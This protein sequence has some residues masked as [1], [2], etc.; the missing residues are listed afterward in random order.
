MI[1]ADLERE[2]WTKDIE[3]E[4]FDYIIFADVLE[5]LRDPSSAVLSALLYLKSTGEVLISVPN[6]TY[7]GVIA[8]MLEGRFDYRRDGLLDETHT[9]F[10]T[11]RSLVQLLGKVGLVSVEWDRTVL[12]PEFSEFRLQTN[13]LGAATRG[14]LAGVPDGDTYQFLVRCAQTGVAALAAPSQKQ[15]TG[16]AGLSAQVYFDTGGGFSEE[17]SQVLALKNGLSK[18]EIHFE[19]PPGIQVIRFDPVDATVPLVIHAVSICTAGQELLHWTAEKGPLGRV[20]GLVNVV[21]L[22]ARGSSVLIP[23][24]NDPAITFVTH[25]SEPVQVSVALSFTSL[26]TLTSLVGLIEPLTQEL[27]LVKEHSRALEHHAKGIESVNETLQSTVTSQALRLREFQCSL[28][29]L[30]SEKLQL[31]QSLNALVR[32]RS[33]LMTRPFRIGMRAARIALRLSKRTLK[34]C[35]KN[36]IL[37]SPLVCRSR[38]AAKV[39]RYLALG[40]EYELRLAQVEPRKKELNV[41]RAKAETLCEPTFSILMPTF[42]TNPGWLVQAIES[43]KRQVYPHWELCIVDDASEDPGV[44]S[45]L[46]TY[47]AHDARIKVQMLSEN[48]HISRASNAALA[49]ATG[50]YI[51]L[52]DHDDVLAPHALFRLAEVIHRERDVDVIYSDEDKISGD[53]QR[54]EPTCK[55]EWSPDYFLSF[56]YTGH[57][58]CFRTGIVRELEGFRPGFEGSQDYDLMLRITERTDR[59]V[60]IPEVLYH[61]RAHGESVAGN[62][63]CKPYAFASAK[64]AISQALERRGFSAACVADSRVRGLYSVDRR[65]KSVLHMT[66]SVLSGRGHI[67]SDSDSLR[68]Y[69][70][71]EAPKLIQDL[72]TQHQGKDGCI[73]ICFMTSVYPGV[74]D[75]LL[76]HC[77]DDLIGVAAP[78]VVNERRDVV[79]AGMS[80][81]GKEV[82]LNFKGI[83]STEIGYRGRLVVPFNVSLVHPACVVFKRT[84][85]QDLP[86]GLTSIAEFVG[87]LCL[88]AGKRGLRCVVDPSQ[89]V[90]VEDEGISALA[91]EELSALM[92]HFGY[93]P[94]DDPFL[95]AG[96]RVYVGCREMPAQ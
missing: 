79:A 52:L 2:D 60:H 93:K 56:M 67:Q 31:E 46:S 62:L 96:L 29:G 95:P 70:Q 89:S 47:A 82:V 41:M 76:D 59:I 81:V 1:V 53:G 16:F 35:F 90:T 71:D 9:H 4:K 64:K 18:Q 25:S 40:T 78:L 7:V 58:S 8:E 32:S 72:L 44:R 42:K 13:Q 49:T 87:A 74:I 73:A 30:Q 88:A 5:H 45:I 17:N 75:R 92:S 26:E 34:T 20:S 85:L 48:V 11:R 3:G 12:A 19:C 10:F 80:F 94:K 65:E 27:E 6:I 55:P 83:A 51:V 14:V 21:E 61:W 43:V 50:S 24:S 38:A 22:F 28:E 69:H 77:A 33:W 15:E 39:W 68:E 66:A 63:D 84:L 54:S 86:S 91:A 37:L 23:L 36:S 57:I